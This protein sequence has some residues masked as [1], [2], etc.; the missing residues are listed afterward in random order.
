MDTPSRADVPR[1]LNALELSAKSKRNLHS[2]L[3][4]ALSEAADRKLVPGNPAKGMLRNDVFHKHTGAPALRA[5]AAVLPVAPRIYDLRHTHASW[6]IQS[7]VALTAIQRRLGHES[8]KTTS[9]V[10]GHLADEA[11]RLTAGKTVA[12]IRARTGLARSPVYAILERNRVEDRAREGERSMT[13]LSRGVGGLG[14]AVPRA[15]P[16][17][18]TTS[19]PLCRGRAGR[20][21]APAG[22]PGARPGDHTTGLALRAGLS[23]Q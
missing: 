2:I 13:V 3:S 14:E 8:I 21:G 23:N 18:A 6:L 12:Q 15:H 16:Y 9:D 10:Y 22:G 19:A 5:C 20:R 17:P 11:D 4:A 1:W 7:A